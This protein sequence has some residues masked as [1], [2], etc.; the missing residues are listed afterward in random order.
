MER[1]KGDLLLS[2]QKKPVGIYL[3][4]YSHYSFKDSIVCSW[5]QSSRRKK[6]FKALFYT[7]SSL[8]GADLQ[9]AYLSGADLSG[10]NLSGTNLKWANLDGANLTGA[11]LTRA[12]LRGANLRGAYLKGANLL[13]IKYNTYTVWPEGFKP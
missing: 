11:K 1:K 12:D 9:G 7:E 3:G 4:N 10:A 8:S 5:G 2:W 6:A 13:N